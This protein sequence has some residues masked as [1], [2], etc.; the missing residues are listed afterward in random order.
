LFDTADDG[1]IL[2]A[3]TGFR[4]SGAAASNKILKGDGTNFIAS[5][6]TYAAP[7]TSGNLM[8][9]D[10]TNWTSVTPKTQV[11]ADSPNSIV[12]INVLTGAPATLVTKSITYS[13][14][15]TVIITAFGQI[16]N[17]SGAVATYSIKFN[18]GSMT[19]TMAFAGTIAASA[20]VRTP[21]EIQ[22]VV[23]IL[24]TSSAWLFGRDLA[25]VG[26]NLG[27]ASGINATNF[28]RYVNQQ[29]SSNLTGAQTTNVQMFSSTNTATQS[30]ELAAYT[31]QK[32]TTNP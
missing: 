5:T 9:S 4:I 12:A 30:F 16:V 29:S 6:E 10:G 2:S 22:L 28:C 27:T 7:S 23:S 31:I 8:Q 17:N 20:T 11:F 13:A 25:A 15:D 26:A 3:G 32:F 18:I 21:V 24:S 1:T 19:A 14:G